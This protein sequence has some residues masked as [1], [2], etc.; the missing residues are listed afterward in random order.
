VS[1]ERGRQAYQDKLKPTP[2]QE[3]PLAEVVWRCRTLDTT[4]LEQRLTAYCRGGVTLTGS[5]QHAEWPELK[6]SL[7]E[8]EAIHCQVLQDGLTRL[9]KT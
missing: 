7:P 8:Y 4:A 1:E 9:D 6:A 5:Q 3:G 2:A